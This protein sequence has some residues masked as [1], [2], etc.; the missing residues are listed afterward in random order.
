MSSRRKS[1]RKSGVGASAIDAPPTTESPS[2]AASVRQ[3]RITPRNSLT[4]DAEAAKP[5][6]TPYTALRQLANIIP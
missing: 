4:E 5:K 3:P 2:V 1:A 6:E